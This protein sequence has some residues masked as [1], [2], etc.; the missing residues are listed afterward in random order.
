MICAG[1]GFRKRRPGDWG[2]LLQI[3]FFLSVDAKEQTV[4]V[5]GSP[6]REILQLKLQ[7]INVFS[8][9]TLQD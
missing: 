6:E 1:T 5:K 2:P 4:L 7:D 9:K 3:V 8:M